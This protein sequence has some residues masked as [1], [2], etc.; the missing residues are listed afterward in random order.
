MYKEKSFVQFQVCVLTLEA[1]ANSFLTAKF[2]PE[3][4]LLIVC[5]LNTDLHY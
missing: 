4:Q 5:H 3:V 1:T 2:V